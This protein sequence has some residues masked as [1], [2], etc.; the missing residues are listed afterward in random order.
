MFVSI[1]DVLS[2]FIKLSL[3]CYCGREH[4]ILLGTHKFVRLLNNNQECIQAC[5]K[6]TY[7]FFERSCFRN[8]YLFLPR[9]H[10]TT[11]ILQFVLWQSML[12]LK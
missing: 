8:T 3:A 6:R 7:A 9:P 5:F 11:K 10:L 2:R 1:T 12:Q 4:N